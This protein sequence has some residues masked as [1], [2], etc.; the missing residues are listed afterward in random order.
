MSASLHLCKYNENAYSVLKQMDELYNNSFDEN[1]NIISKQ[2]VEYNKL[3]EQNRN[4]ETFEKHYRLAMLRHHK[5][6]TM[7]SFIKKWNHRFV[8]H[9]NEN[10]YIIPIETILYHSSRSIKLKRKW[11]QR[12]AWCH[13]ITTKKGL[14]GFMKQY[15]EKES[16]STFIKDIIN[17]FIEGET[18]LDVTY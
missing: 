17:P 4:L 6:K 3:Y 16:Y 8:K 15:V 9:W 14:Y 2:Y 11:F 1:D 12:E 10:E 18:F 13:V 5:S 7:K